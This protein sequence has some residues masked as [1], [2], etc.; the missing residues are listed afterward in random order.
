MSAFTKG[1]SFPCSYFPYLRGSNAVVARAPILAPEDVKTL[2]SV[3]Q[4]EAV[5]GG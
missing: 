3:W 4:D 2:F 5:R 1:C